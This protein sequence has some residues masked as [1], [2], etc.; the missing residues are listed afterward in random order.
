MN[1]AVTSSLCPECLVVVPARRVID[2]NSVFLEKEC[3]HHGHFRTLIWRGEPSYAEWAQGSE[4][5]KPTAPSLRAVSE[6][7][8]DCGLCE[9]HEGETCIAVLHL[10]QQC[11]LSCPVCFA[12]SNN[13]HAPEPPVPD[14]VRM[15]AACA[16]KA[17]IPSVQL[18]GGEPTMRD[19]LPDIVRMGKLLGIDHLQVNTNGLRLAHDP[20]YAFRLKAAGLDIVYLQFDGVSDAVYRQLR[21][22]S[23]LDAKI[24]ALTSCRAA[25]LPALLVP[26][27]VPGIND[28]EI[29]EII[30]LAKRWMP[31][32]KG[33]HFQPI[34]YFGRYPRQGPSPQDRFTIPDLLE[35]LQ[36]QTKG[37]IR[38]DAMIPR[39][40][41]DSHCSFSGVFVTN[42]DGRLHA[43][44]RSTDRSARD[45]K[46]YAHDLFAEEAV[47]FA[48]RFWR[49]E[50]KETA[51]CCSCDSQ[52]GKPS[53]ETALRDRM[54]TI[55]GMQFQDV[56][57]ID[58]QRLK[59]CCVHV[60]TPDCRFVPLCAYYLTSASGQIL[61]KEVNG[62]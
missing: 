58:L 9:D 2:D 4:H 8:L 3:E 15:L 30:E 59:G 46:D 52:A 38:S 45:P 42:Q 40:K 31:T 57:N 54:L 13:R 39:R 51:P 29:G 50:A 35:S 14:V 23:L 49:S 22:R 56:W 48:D 18:S 44:S 61:R 6:C 41:F 11:N 16:E 17:V 32:V 47:A 34:S 1:S 43:V 21:G 62:R 60:V 55:S 10:T 5:A 7:P 27:V 28:G 36:E 12:D 25:G 19:D 26:T 24:A 20:D 37:E 53:L 33:V